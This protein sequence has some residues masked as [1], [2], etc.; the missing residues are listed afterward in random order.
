MIQTL[1]LAECSKTY[2]Q[3]IPQLF[4]GYASQVV[5]LWEYPET[6]IDSHAPHH[7]LIADEAFVTKGPGPACT[8]IASLLEAKTIV[9]LPRLVLMRREKIIRELPHGVFQLRRPFYSEELEKILA[10][11]CPEGRKMKEV[12]MEENTNLMPSSFTFFMSGEEETRSLDEE[13]IQKM[14]REAIEKAVREILPSIAEKIIREEI[15]R[16]T[17]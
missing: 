16:L 12:P 8:T 15:E 1:Y 10:K 9:T 2:R 4:E 7:L 11:L 13:A 17:K 6:I 3:W 5:D 14:T